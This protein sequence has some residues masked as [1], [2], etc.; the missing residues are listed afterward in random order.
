MADDGTWDTVS[1]RLPTIADAAGQVDRAVLVDSTIARGASA[2]HQHHP[3][4]K[5]AGSN[6][7]DPRVEPPEHA[8]GRSR[9]GWSTTVHHLST[10]TA[11]R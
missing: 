7:T 4:H 11:G 10:D 6:Y 5:G 2:R 8:I 9:G 3:R 1:Q